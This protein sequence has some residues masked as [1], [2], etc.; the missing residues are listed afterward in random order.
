MTVHIIFNAHLDPIWLWSWRDGLD[1]VLNTSYYICNLLDRHPDIIYTRGE[2]WVYEQIQ[3]VD[4]A[5]FKR[6]QEHVKAGRWSTVGGWYIQPDC[7]LPSGFA[8]ERQIEIG[9]RQ[10]SEFFGESP[11][12]GY[13]VD[14]FGHSAALPDLMRRAGQEFYVMMRPG[15]SEKAL[16]ARLFRW[17]GHVDGREVITFRIASSNSYGYCT[18]DGITEQHIQAAI[19]ELPADISH[20]MYFVGIGDHGGGP[21]EEMI[22]WCRDH[23]NSI[24]GVE[25]VFS[26]PAK[27]FAAIKDDVAKLPEVVGEL[28]MHA[29]GCYSVHRS[30][31]L[32]VRKAEHRLIQAESVLRSSRTPAKDDVAALEAA[33]KRLCFHHFHDT[34]CGTCTPSAYQDVDAQLGEV[35]TAA[36]DLATYAFRKRVVE[37]ADDPAQRIVLLNASERPFADYVEVEPFLEWTRWQPSWRLL[38]ETDK[39]V[40]LQI[41]DPESN[42][43]TQTRLLFPVSAKP[44]QLQTLRIV[45]SGLSEEPQPNA[46]TASHTALLSADGPSLHLGEPG[47]MDFPLAKKLPLPLLALYD[48]PTDT[49]SHNAD[50]FAR[51][52]K[53]TAVWQE[54]KILDR[55]PLMSS[56]CQNG[57]I[58]SSELQ[59]EWRIYQGKPWIECRLRVGWTEKRRILKFEWE[60]P[61]EISK[62]EDGIMEGSLIRQTDGCE[63]PVRD[64]VRL[65]LKTDESPLNVAVVAPE[66]FSV[67][68]EPKRL[69]MTL[70]RSPVMAW[71]EPNPAPQSRSVYSD[72][73]EH[74]FRFRFLA[75][76]NVTA[77]D[78]E[79]ISIAWQ[80]P[81]LSAELTRGMRNRNLRA[82]YTPVRVNL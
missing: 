13:N 73:G 49:W 17:R 3:R 58:G 51:V 20:T 25:L 75:D 79:H 80:R 53:K 16:P 30:V 55:G 69:A 39:P 61:W 23:R 18:P 1:E 36:D 24:P 59:I 64:W 7:N 44:G 81:L 40:M 74:F 21:T 28:Q 78:L 22:Q 54:P 37:L 8:M 60:L 47:T 70:L 19:S 56:L 27:Y 72:R 67:D 33:W 4:P 43:D 65:E 14:S 50:R 32:S 76:E 48:D 34:L 6:I 68:C 10:F 42:G 82:K 26:S 62:R 63:R 5:L 45:D 11:K 77:A 52:N 12:V 35:L 2:A 15:E 9:R 38:D 31:K 71:H 29:V 46:V 41:I 66:I 57:M